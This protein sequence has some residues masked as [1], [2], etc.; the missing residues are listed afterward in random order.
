[1]IPYLLDY[2]WI[3]SHNTWTDC[4]VPTYAAMKKAYQHNG[5]AML[6]GE[7]M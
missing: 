2:G 4:P 3:V 1:M 6:F 5:N 7:M